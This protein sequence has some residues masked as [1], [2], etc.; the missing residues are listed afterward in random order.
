MLTSS[1]S[2]ISVGYSTELELREKGD[3]IDDALFATKAAIESGFVPGGG[4]A[5]LSAANMI[6]TDCLDGN[7]KSSAECFLDAC[8]SPFRQICDN[9]EVNHAIVEGRIMSEF[10]SD[11]MFGYNV[12]SDEYGDMVSMGVIDPTKVTLTALKNASSIAI[13]LLTTNA[14]MSESKHDESG[15]QPPAGWRLPDDSKLN[16]KY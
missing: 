8:K 15:W 5:L 11:K 7:I 16:H 12:A 4:V 10:S 14:V 6:D 9:A 2:I 3:R 1:A 13:L